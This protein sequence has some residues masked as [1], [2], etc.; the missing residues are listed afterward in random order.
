MLEQTFQVS[1]RESLTV[2]VGGFES[3]KTGKEVNFH[4]NTHDLPEYSRIPRK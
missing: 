1:E 3:M 2:I 4:R